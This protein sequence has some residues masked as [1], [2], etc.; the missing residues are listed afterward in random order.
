[1]TCDQARDALLVADLRELTSGSSDLVTHLSACADCRG[2][3]DVVITRTAALGAMVRRRARRR[4]SRWILAAASLPIAA[5]LIAVAI[6]RL[7][8]PEPALSSRR[9]SSLPVARHV[10]LTVERGQTATVL[11]TADPS[12]TVIWLSPGVGQ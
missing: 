2:R 12:V 10:S 5:G 4:R 7:T 8:A 3:A 1:M 6:L 11:K 9:T